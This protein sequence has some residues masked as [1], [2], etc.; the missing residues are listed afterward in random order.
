MVGVWL[1]YR[2][3]GVLYISGLIVVVEIEYSAKEVE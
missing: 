3:Y 1:D 2:L